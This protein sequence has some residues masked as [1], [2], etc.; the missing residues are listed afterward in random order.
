MVATDAGPVPTRSSVAPRPDTR[1]L[2]EAEPETW[3][4]LLRVMA[5]LPLLLDAQLERTSGLN[6]FEYTIL[7]M[8]SE[9]PGSALRMSRSASVTNACPSKLSHAARLL[10]AR[11]Y[12]TRE[13]DPEDGRCIR[14]VLTDPGRELV[15][16]AAPGHVAA[17]RDLF[18]DSLAPARLRQ[19]RRVNERIRDE[20][21]PEGSTRPDGAGDTVPDR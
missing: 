13:A 15:V 16:G 8:L 14:A 2:A 11:G 5:K 10:E 4:S 17:G 1:W 20:V 21:D 6:L 7:A 12:L 19:L 9:Q 18:L 3:L